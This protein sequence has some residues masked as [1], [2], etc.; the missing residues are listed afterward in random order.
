MQTKFE[1]IQSRVYFRLIWFLE[2]I[3][4]FLWQVVMDALP[5]NFLQFSHHITDDPHYSRCNLNLYESSLHVLRDCSMA[6]A[7]C[8]RLISAKD[9]PQ[10]STAGTRTW[11]Y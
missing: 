4:V 7:F 6:G 8:S 11:I 2:R 1:T 5:T 10:F 3:R 9:Y